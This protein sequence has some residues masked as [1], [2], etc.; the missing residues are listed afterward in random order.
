MSDVRHST[1]MK[2]VATQSEALSK[3]YE[4]L[5]DTGEGFEEE[6]ARVDPRTGK[7]LESVY[8]A[9]QWWLMWRK[10][11]RNK[12][13]IVGG[14]IILL[15]YLTALFADFIVPYT[16]TTRLRGYI[17]MPPQRIH[18]INEGRFQPFVYDVNLTIDKN[19]RKTY[20]PDLTK[21]HPIQFFAHG[22]PYKLFKL[23]S[24]GGSGLL[25][26]HRPAGAGS[27]FARSPGE[28]GLANDWPGRSALES[29]SRLGAGRHLGLLR[30]LGG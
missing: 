20:T 13:A 25:A 9:S 12:A 16:L 30:W 24:A 11:I 23:L 22:D 3:L 1:H 4:G 21:K 14:I 18:F 19:L 7:P 27:V 17:Y 10:F 26:G 28:P 29:G 6:E 8:G 15:F 2:D 5:A